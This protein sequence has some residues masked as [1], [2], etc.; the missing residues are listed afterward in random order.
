MGFTPLGR[1]FTLPCFGF[2][3]L[4]GLSLGFTPLTTRGLPPKW[5]PP[6]VSRQRGKPSNRFNNEFDNFFG[7][8]GNWISGLYLGFTPLA[9]P[10]QI[11]G[12]IYLGFIPLGRGFTP[13]ALLWVYPFDWAK[14]GVYPL[15]TRGLPPK[16]APPHVSRQR[17][18][19]SNRFNNEFDHF[20]AGVEIG[21]LASTWGLPPWPGLGGLLESSTWGLP[22]WPGVY[23]PLLWVYPFDWAKP[24]VYPPDHTGFTLQ[25][26]S[27]PRF[28]AKR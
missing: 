6:H 2:T 4:I 11:I 7:G 12:I 28:E 14:P 16:W 23:P 9:W 26:G 5:A 27:P 3:L 22:P 25:M 13:L 1:G 15:A 18:K 24:R 10:W 19:P 17:G 20:L 8:R 21:I